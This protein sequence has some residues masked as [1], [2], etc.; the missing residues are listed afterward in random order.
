MSSYKVLSYTESTAGTARTLAELAGGTVPDG[1][2]FAR[3][4]VEGQDCR[5]T[6]DGTTP[7][8]LIGI[9]VPKAAAANAGQPLIVR[10]AQFAR[11]LL[12]EVAASATVRVEFCR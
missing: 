8:A 12:I 9:L 7:T 10:R 4:W 5:Y 2:Q 3:V 1:C 11:F 6:Q